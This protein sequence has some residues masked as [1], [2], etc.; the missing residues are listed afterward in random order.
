MKVISNEFGRIIVVYNRDEVMPDGG[1]YLPDIIELFAERYKFVKLPIPNNVNG[2]MDIKF[3]NGQ[4]KTNGKRIN[5]KE[6]VLYD[7]GLAIVTSN[8]DSAGDVLK[9]VLDWGGPTIGLRAPLSGPLAA[10][11]NHVVVDF[12]NPINK[13]MHPIDILKKAFEDAMTA[14]YKQPV[15]SYFTSFGIGADPLDPVRAPKAQFSISRRVGVPYTEN[16]FYC[17]APLSTSEHHN[18]LQDFD[19]SLSF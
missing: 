5:I 19:D 6:M 4:I 14:R 17:V 3:E 8:T 16:R 18:L 1:Y 12:D 15:E 2:G 13:I 7:D 9:D 11:E 10:L